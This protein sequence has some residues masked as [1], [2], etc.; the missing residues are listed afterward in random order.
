M[1]YILVE[2]IDYMHNSSVQQHSSN[3]YKLSSIHD[4]DSY[5]AKQI[6]EGACTYTHTLLVQLDQ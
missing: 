4:E 2:K 1:A 5:I 3:D 6:S